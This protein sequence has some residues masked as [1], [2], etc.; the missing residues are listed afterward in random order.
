[1]MVYSRHD[2]QWKGRELRLNTGRLLG[3][4]EPDSEW[5]GM[6]RVRLPDGWLSDMVNLT[7]A[8]DAAISLS[9]GRLNQ[10]QETRAEGVY[11]A[12]NGRAI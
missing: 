2:L 4:I 10:H 5:A 7:R 12:A 3:T 8:K 6:F 9:L 11:V 1:M